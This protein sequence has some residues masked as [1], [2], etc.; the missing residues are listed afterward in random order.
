MKVDNELLWLTGVV[1]G[2]LGISSLVGWIMSRQEL[3]DSARRT[4]ENLN[5]RT[6][7]W[8]VMTAVFALALA[9]GGIGSVVLFAFSSFLALREFLTLTPTRAGDHRTMFW[10]FFVV[11]P[12]QY[13]LLWFEWYPVFVIF[14]P[15]YV[16][17]FLPIRSA[18]AGETE[19]FLERTAKIQWGVMICV[20]CL[21]HAPALLTLLKIPGYEHENGKLLYYFVLICELSDVM[22]YVFG[23][24]FGR[25][26][27]APTVSPG[28][29]WEG[30][31][32]GVAAT[33]AI[34][35]GLWWATPFTPWQSAGMSLLTCLMGFG[36][37]L[38]MSAIKRDR[39]VKDWGTTIKGHGGMLD[40]LDSLC[41]AAPIFFHVTRYYF[42]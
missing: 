18:A 23:K 7:A 11:C 8:W 6:R 35:A 31:I 30:L 41:F 20:Y 34:G 39:G 22:Q 21:S 38:V 33:V 29:T 2:L 5:E 15:V 25:H 28:K 37:G 27:V 13:V 3:S 26:Q 19:N 24:L 36:G 16:F 12:M 9:T 42:A 32:G 10:A 40:R 14:I 1:V 4:V 17:L